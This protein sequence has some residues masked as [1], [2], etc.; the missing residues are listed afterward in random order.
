MYVELFSSILYSLKQYCCY[1][2]RVK[3]LF[4]CYPFPIFNSSK[5][6]MLSLHMRI[7]IDS[8]NPFTL[9]M[10]EKWVFHNHS[11]KLAVI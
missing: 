2:Q 11:E 9:N 4:N 6:N 5:E 3:I 1:T 7:D 8:D 10:Y